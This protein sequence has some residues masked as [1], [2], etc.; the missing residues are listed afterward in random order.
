M[1]RYR[2]REFWISCK[3]AKVRLRDVSLVRMTSELIG[4]DDQ[5]GSSE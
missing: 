4:K 5:I 1:Y 3:L 2:L